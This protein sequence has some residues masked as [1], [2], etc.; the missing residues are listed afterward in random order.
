MLRSV[1]VTE[2]ED[3]K[4]VTVRVWLPDTVPEV[5]LMIAVP[6]ATAVAKPLLLTVATDGSD[7][8]QVTRLVM[9]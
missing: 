3:S 6:A 7:E 9:S 8:S 2:T 5:A 4:D 1:G